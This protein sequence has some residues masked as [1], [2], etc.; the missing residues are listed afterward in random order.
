[1]NQ[2]R[3]TLSARAEVA[4]DASPDRRQRTVHPQGASPPVDDARPEDRHPSPRTRGDPI[5]QHRFAGALGGAVGIVR[6]GGVGGNVRLCDAALCRSVHGDGAQEDDAADTG[7][8]RCSEEGPKLVRHRHRVPARR[9][10]DG[11]CPGTG[12]VQAAGLVE[13]APHC[14][15]VGRAVRWKPVKSGPYRESRPA[16]LRNRRPAD[17]PARAGDEDRPCHRAPARAPRPSIGP[18]R[19]TRDRK[20]ARLIRKR[21]GM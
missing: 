16:K 19:C 9:V 12:G 4:E 17:E 5:P 3:Q 18:I 2:S 10:H 11:G 7:P 20:L 13:V 8:V 21:S 15:V 1:M 14:P 6:G